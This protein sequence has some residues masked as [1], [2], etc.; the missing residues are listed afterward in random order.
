VE[1]NRWGDWIDVPESDHVVFARVG[2]ERSWWTTVSTLLLRD[3]AMYIQVRFESGEEKTYRF[4]RAQAESGLWMSPLPRDAI[5]LRS[6]LSRRFSGPRARAIRFRGG[7]EELRPSV[8]IS[9]LESAL[10]RR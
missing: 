7:E 6:I 10:D 8:K 5:E 4:L 2:F 3:A 9:W 1:E